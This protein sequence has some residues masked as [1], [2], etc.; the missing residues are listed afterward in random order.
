MPER[1]VELWDRLVASDPGLGRIRMAG[2]SAISMASALA[3]EYGFALLIGADAK[4]MLVVMLLGAMVAMMGAQALSGTGV[5]P[6][7]RTALFFPVALGAGMCAGVSV[8]GN[9]DLMLGVFVVVMFVAVFIRKFGIPYFFYGFMGWMGYFFSS[10]LHATFDMLPLLL[11]AI[12]IGTVWVVLLSITV[13]RENPARTLNRAVRGFDAR[14]RAMARA[15]AVLLVDREPDEARVARAWR[16][17]QRSHANLAEIAL[18]VEAMSGEPGALPA[19]DSPVVLRRKLVEAQQ[20]MDRMATAAK[21]L[22]SAEPSLRLMAARVADRLARRD[23]QGANRGA[24]ELAER[25]EP[26]GDG[27]TEPGSEGWWAARH[28]AAAVLEFVALARSRG[29]LAPH[30]D[31][32]LD[33]FEPVVELVMGNLPGSPAA[34]R[35]VHARGHRWNPLAR[36]AMS[37]RQAVQ[38]A[39]AGGLAILVGR[40]L[41][42][43]RY[44]WAVLAAFLMF[45]GTATRSEQFIKGWNRVFGTL[46]GL[47]V[48]IGFAELTAGQPIWSIVVIVASMFCGFYLMRLSYA[49]MIFFLTIMLGQLYSVLHEFSPGFLLLRLEET[50]VGAG[51]GFLV[52]LVVM[53]LSTRDT[54]RSARDA[55]LHQLA[56]LLHAAA[57]RLDPVAGGESADLAGLSRTLDDRM[58][59]LSLVA[60]PM[61]RPLLWNNSPR[62]VRHRLSLYASIATSTRALTV[63]LRDAPPVRQRGLAAA[64][65]ALATAGEELARV[66]IGRDQPSASDPLVA[67]D[68]ALFGRT[69]AVPGARASSPVLR[70]LTHVH[71]SLRELSTPSETALVETRLG[72]TVVGQ[73]ITDSGEPVSARVTLLHPSGYEAAHAETNPLTGYYR[74]SDCAAGHYLTA[75]T[76]S[77][78]ESVAGRVRV[79]VRAPAAADFILSTQS[80]ARSSVH[81]TIRDP[82]GEPHP[83]AAVAVFA[84]DGGLLAHTHADRQGRYRLDLDPGTYNM[85][86]TGYATVTTKTR[87]SGD[88]LNQLD[89][90]L[91]RADLATDEHANLSELRFP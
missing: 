2:S 42:E 73:V 54:F 40:E 66:R 15:V 74:F 39:I 31:A 57:T 60:K 56:E 34:A 50:A 10:F 20:T 21:A 36:M 5:W 72:N 41:S 85:I 91:P 16:R 90:V 26:A 49:Y 77:G 38:V 47:G 44:Y 46:V 55:F 89:L 70:T 23:D 69:V 81:G 30:D 53:P 14:T 32:E 43:T 25:S 75:V 28:F 78:Q 37:S 48:S 68:V 63:A 24:H 87:L 64:C 9:T 65:R 12:V 82:H 35:E 19:G 62:Q 33:E 59:Q 86:T 29:D 27:E 80:A 45:A 17:I 51:I 22:V 11:V 71:Q 13:L 6:K 67:A 3:V 52:A 18:M 61:T 76:T 79:H 4:L 8:S 83:E 58:R 1:L 88:R 7:V 84:S